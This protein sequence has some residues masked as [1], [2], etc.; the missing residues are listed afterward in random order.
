M[1]AGTYTY[2]TLA[3]EGTSDHRDRGSK[4]FGYAYPVQN[5]DDA[6]LKLQSLKKLHPKASHYCFAWRLGFDGDIIR[7][8][9]DG[10]PSGSAGRPIEGQILSAGLTNVLVVVVRY[11][12]GTLLGV[13]G[14]IEAYRTA[15]AQALA[16]AGKVERHVEHRVLVQ[17]DYTMM[18]EVMQVVKQCGCTI[19]KQEMGL[20]CCYELLVPLERKELVVSRLTDIR[21]VE[22]LP[23]G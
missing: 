6:K 21:G 10:E 20:Y 9:D 1:S 8:S 3:G 18:N 22:L 5:A 4:F 12:G 13:P 19:G 23:K 2:F 11:F 16:V 14:L 7:L 15:A 17:F